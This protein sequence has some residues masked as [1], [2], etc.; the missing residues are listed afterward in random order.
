MNTQIKKQI[1]KFIDK[2][3]YKGFDYLYKHVKNNFPN[4]NKKEL[5]ELI[6][7][8]L[9]DKFIKEW[10]INQYMVK[11]F[12]SRPD[13]WFHDLM[14]NGNNNNPRYWHIF[15]G[16]NNRYAVAL[17]LK[18][19]NADDI[20]KTLKY[21]VNKYKP[22]KLTSDEEPG[23]VEKNNLEFLTNNNVNVQL[24]TDKNHS[25]LGIIDRF[26][27]TL[28]DLNTPHEHSKHQSHHDKYKTIN[29]ER[30]NKLLNIY[31]NTYHSAIKCTPK[32]MF[33]DKNK[34]KEYI[35]DCLDK[36]QKQKNIKDFKLN[37]GDFVRFTIPRA[38][39]ITKKR[40]QISKE[41]YKIDSITGN[42]Y[43]LIAQDG[44]VIDKPRFK[45][46]LCK[47]DGSK[48][49]N[50]KWATTIPNKWNGSIKTI[51]SYNP[52]T[53]KYN[54]T[55]KVPGQNDYIDDIPPTNLRGNYPQVLSDLEKQFR[56]LP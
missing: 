14:D 39:G 20:N 26:I 25:S 53:N 32:E 17:E 1:N 38:D 51:N 21:F 16:T 40:Y 10:Q 3:H 55:F 22:I 52:Q 2:R 45:I 4:I 42:M 11:I 5:Q 29:P 50:I 23:F 24:I 41:C 48:P 37:I 30:M 33:D 43:T 18:S 31:N 28:R 9:Q 13:T 56:N 34:E 44:T 46:F 8:R 15:I 49:N 19:K 35:F 12:S 54:I 47:K 7:K 36:N 6:E 27:R